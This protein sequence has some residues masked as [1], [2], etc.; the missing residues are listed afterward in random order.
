M[1]AELAQAAEERNEQLKRHK[2]DAF[3]IALAKLPADV[4]AQADVIR[5]GVLLQNPRD[6]S[7]KQV[8]LL[9]KYPML[10]IATGTLAQLYPERYRKELKEY[11]ERVASINTR[12]P[13]ENFV[14]ALFETPDKVPVTRLFRRGS[15]TQ[16]AEDVPPAG[17]F[18]FRP[19]VRPVPR[20]GC[21]TALV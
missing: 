1:D 6:R 15:H 13:Q 20:S 3:D 2:A 18:N 10:N 19:S 16:P 7:P 4:Q 21:P 12:R 5:E 11:E 9:N 14:R 17:L 8:A